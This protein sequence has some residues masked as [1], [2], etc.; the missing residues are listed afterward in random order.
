MRYLYSLKK[1]STNLLENRDFI[2][3]A[4]KISILE[5]YPLMNLNQSFLKF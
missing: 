3:L 5:L 1:I 2:G 4:R